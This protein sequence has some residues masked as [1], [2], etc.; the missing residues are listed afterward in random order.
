MR[1]YARRTPTTP[2]TTFNNFQILPTHN[3]H[4]PA[5]CKDCPIAHVT[6][7]YVPLCRGSGS[8]LWVGEAAGE[9]EAQ[10]GKPFVGGAGTWLNSMCKAAKISRSTLNIINT[11]GCKPPEN[12]YPLDSKWYWTD[13]A[14]ARTAVEHCAAHHL[15][16]A[17][18]GRKWSRIVALGDWALQALTPRRSILIWRG[19]PLPLK[20]DIAGGPRVMPTLHP[21]FLM[22]SASMFSVAVRDLRKPLTLPPEHYNLWPTLADLQRFTSTE[23]SF[24]FEW[25]QWGN[26]TLCGLSDRYYHAMVVPFEEP[27]ITELKRIFEGAKVLIGQN[28]VGADTKYF[29]RLG[30]NVNA[31]LVD[32][33]LIQHLVQ[34]DMRHNLGFI[35]SVFAN[36]VFWKGQGEETEDDEGNVVPAG[37]QWRTWDTA[38]AIPREHG[39]YGG[40]TSGEEAYRLY[41]ARDT[42][43][44]LQCVGPLRATLAK[45]RMDHVYRNVSVPAAFICRDIS[46]AG[47]RIDSARVGRIRE[48]LET[49]IAELEVTLPQGLAPYEEPCMKQVVA[50]PGTYRPKVVKCRG[51]KKYGGAHEEQCYTFHQPGTVVCSVCGRVVDSGKLAEAKVLRVAATRRITPWNST[52]QVKRFAAELGCKAAVNK[53]TGRETADKRAR[54]A[55][56][57]EHP[58][59][60]IVD[61][62]KKLV[63]QRNSFAK[64]GLLATDRVYFN[65]LVHGTS[66]GRLSSSGRRRGIDPNIQN[67]PKAIRKIFLPDEE[68]WGILSLDVRSGE[69]MITAWLAQD[70]ARLERLRTPGYDEHSEL[71]SRIFN[72]PINKKDKG[73]LALR[74]AAKV[75]NHGKNYGMGPRHMQENLALEGYAYTFSEVIEMNEEWA[76]LNPGTAAWQRAVTALAQRQG[77]LENPFGRRRWFQSRDFATK[78]LAFLPASTLADVVLRMM[79]AFYPER[80]PKQLD[81][82]GLQVVGS[83]PAQWRMFVQVHD[84]LAFTGPHETRYQMA[85]LARAIM[86][87]PWRELQN[88]TLG[89]EI[90]YSTVSWGDVE[91]FDPDKEEAVAAAALP[92]AA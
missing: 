75:I 22:R 39:G 63:T 20:D 85:R 10:S 30:W 34:P 1:Q 76:R 8:E 67:Q 12:V 44:C 91:E 53:K 51:G 5:F 64:P 45:Y 55:W 59:F 56:A 17:V 52:D 87:Q 62:L 4:R 2:T 32:T 29:E 21:A 49:Q 90:N 84:E 31:D 11:I 35:A 71:A 57:R 41:N 74:K 83:L 6:E 78:A 43:K 73:F 66:E 68:G 80:F 38:E 37:A 40:C 47:M 16:P 23:F 26:I 13:R 15:W 72:V 19:S 25:D 65:L 88:F 46:D 82:L 14:T 61:Q 50:P 36:A 70:H 24:D 28:I 86:T 33:M 7:G 60:T 58:E 9:N 54:K 3:Q 27:Y 18:R 77:F 79:I 92:V 42:E 69:N 89:V 81:E 48:T